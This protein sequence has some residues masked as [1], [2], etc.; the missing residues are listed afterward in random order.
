MLFVHENLG[1]ALVL[2]QEQLQSEKVFGDLKRD[3]ERAHIDVANAITKLRNL[4]E[5]DD[6]TPAN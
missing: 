2:F 5:E 1:K 6:G 4:L 3:V